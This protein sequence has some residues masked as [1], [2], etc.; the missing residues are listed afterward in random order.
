MILLIIQS[1]VG[2]CLCLAVTQTNCMCIRFASCVLFIQSIMKIILHCTN[3][4]LC[5]QDMMV[6][7]LRVGRCRISLCA[8]LQ[9]RF[10][11]VASAREAMR[12]PVGPP[13]N[14]VS[15][16]IALLIRLQAF[17][18]LRF[19]DQPCC[20]LWWL[21][22]WYRQIIFGKKSQHVIAC[23]KCCYLTQGLCPAVAPR[24]V[25]GAVAIFP[26]IVSAGAAWSCIIRITLEARCSV[27]YLAC[28]CLACLGLGACPSLPPVPACRNERL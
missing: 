23:S 11:Q 1:G 24:A 27:L 3:G 18:F 28:D 20:S 12:K 26:C 4:S 6:V 7:M 5:N 9:M 2:T 8:C 25:Q 16:A 10:P 22:F 17:E 13:H 21:K 19:E 15:D 14:E